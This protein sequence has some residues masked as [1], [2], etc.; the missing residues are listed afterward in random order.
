MRLVQGGETSFRCLATVEMGSFFLRPMFSRH[1]TIRAIIRNQS[2]G[3]EQVCCHHIEGV[4]VE[5]VVTFLFMI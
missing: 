1:L 3:R 2:Q 5:K 4:A